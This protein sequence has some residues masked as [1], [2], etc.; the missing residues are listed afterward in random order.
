MFF[1]SGG[2]LVRPLGGRW[3]PGHQFFRICADAGFGVDD[4]ARL[5]SACD[6]AA[7]YLDANHHAVPDE[8]TEERQFAEYYRQVLDALGPAP[9]DVSARLA[10]AI[11]REV[12]FEPFPDTRKVLDRLAR[13]RLRMAVLTDAWPSVR[14]KFRALELHDYFECMVIS[15]EVGCVKPDMG[16]FEPA[17]AVL[18]VQPAEVLFVDD[19]PDLVEAAQANGFRSL[20]A[21]YDDRLPD[22]PRRIRSLSDVLCHVG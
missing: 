10:R 4:D 9:A 6:A 3:F 20:L 5:R 11:V 12:N 2:T 1:D 17:L 15:A 13:R 14:T 18:N 16:M 8:E 19:S 22:F 21:D 7:E